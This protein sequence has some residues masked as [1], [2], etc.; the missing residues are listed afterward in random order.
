[1]RT[2]LSIPP[3]LQHLIEKRVAAERR[4]G[5]DRR[6]ARAAGNSASNS[7]GASRPTPDVSTPSSGSS[8]GE[9]STGQG[10]CEPQ[11]ASSGRR[12]ERR[13]HR[14]RRR[15]SRRVDDR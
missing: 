8:N 9:V 7:A 12:V 13:K 3:S 14:D 15:K 1:M 6:A 11:R 4:S 10:E 5:E 2:R